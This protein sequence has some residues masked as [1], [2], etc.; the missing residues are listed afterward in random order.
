MDAFRQF[1]AD[2]MVAAIVV[3]VVL[4]LATFALT[5]Y[6]SLSDGTFDKSKLPKIL[7][8]LVIRRVVPLGIL[9]IVA[10]ATPV[11][12]TQDAIVALYLAAATLVAAVELGQFKDAL[13]NAGLPELPMTEPAGP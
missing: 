10:I 13:V 1:L 9:G 7:D 11:G 4:S 2:P 8:T 6:R 3:V 12:P 5:V